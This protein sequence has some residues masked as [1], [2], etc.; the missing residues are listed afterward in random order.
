MPSEWL[1]ILECYANK[2]LLTSSAQSIKNGQLIS[3]LLDSIQLPKQLAI[4]KIPGHSK[5]DSVGAKEN[6]LADAA[7][8]QVALGLAPAQTWECAQ[9]KHASNEIV[10]KYL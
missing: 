3:K 5:S 7:V 8:K 10:K 1:M 2:G 9:L 4:F 6:Q